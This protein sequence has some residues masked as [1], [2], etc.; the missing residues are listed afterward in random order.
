MLIPRFFD[1]LVESISGIMSFIYRMMTSN[2]VDSV[3]LV[4]K[5]LREL[6]VATMLSSI[7]DVLQKWFDERSKATFTMKSCLTSWAE[8]VLHLE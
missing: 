1:K 5:D 2:C 3:N 4:F 7:R 8:N 6:P